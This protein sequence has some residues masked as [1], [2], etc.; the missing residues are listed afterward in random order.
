MGTAGAGG[1]MTEGS[2]TDEA[3]DGKET[4][5]SSAGSNADWASSSTL[6][7]VSTIK[8]LLIIERI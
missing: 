6:D 3:T 5:E 8:N 7:S 1:S 2:A 4:M